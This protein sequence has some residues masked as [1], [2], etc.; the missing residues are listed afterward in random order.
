MLGANEQPS[1]RLTE[2]NAWL[3][4]NAYVYHT[5]FRGLLLLLPNTL[6]FIEAFT[7]AS[8]FC[9]IFMVCVFEFLYRY[10]NS[11]LKSR[12]LPVYS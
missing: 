1:L 6:T 8:L 10:L 3:T 7:A 9:T 12:P 4:F 11:A 2:D 5:V